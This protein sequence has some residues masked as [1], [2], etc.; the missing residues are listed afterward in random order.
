MK[1]LKIHL[2]FSLLACNTIL[3]GQEKTEL[4]MTSF[5][6]KSGAYDIYYP[7]SFKLEE[8]K[9]GTV[10]IMDTLSE[11]HITISHYPLDKKLKTE[12]LIELL[13]GFVKS[14]F[15]QEI[16]LEDWKAYESKFDN[17]VELKLKD[18]TTQWIWWGVNN[19]KK[20]IVI[21]ADKNTEITQNEISLIQFMI[22]NLIIK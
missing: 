5:I 22:E 9:D 1:T 14:Y 4:R 19:K 21:S 7:A 13:N 11:L 16:K 17:L 20:L 3:F 6:P 10:A 12:N 2:I 8:N 18:D 15:K